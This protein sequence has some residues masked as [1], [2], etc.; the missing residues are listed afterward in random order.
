MRSARKGLNHAPLEI[1]V[2]LRRQTLDLVGVG[3]GLEVETDRTEPGRPVEDLL[4]RHVVG[5]LHKRK[6]RDVGGAEAVAGRVVDVGVAIGGGTG[7]PDGGDFEGRGR[8]LRVD[9]LASEEY[10]GQEFG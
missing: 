5:P 9:Q 4:H 3:L 8:N 1:A 6:Q 7:G 10:Q 2:L